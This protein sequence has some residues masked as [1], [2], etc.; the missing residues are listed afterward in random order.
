MA[1]RDPA[2]ALAKHRAEMRLALA[3]GLSLAAARD[4]LAR[5]RWIA[6]D[7]RLKRQRCAAAS[8]SHSNCGTAATSQQ[9]PEQWWQR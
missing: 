4:R 3:E 9:L 2:A 7:E 1:V 8:P 6:A 5:A